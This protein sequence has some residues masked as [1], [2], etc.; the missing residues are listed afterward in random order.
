MIKMNMKNLAIAGLL[1]VLPTT[2]LAAQQ[3]ITLA[4]NVPSNKLYVDANGFTRDPSITVTRPAAWP[5][6]IGYWSATDYAW[7]SG[8]PGYVSYDAYATGNLGWAW[9]TIPGADWV[10]WDN[11]T[12]SPGMSYYMGADRKGP[13]HADYEVSFTMPAYFKNAKVD[14]KYSADDWM[15]AYMNNNLFVDQHT[16]TIG[17]YFDGVPSDACG[18][19]CVSTNT[20]AD[21]AMALRPGANKFKVRQWEPDGTGGVA[22]LVNITFDT[23]DIITSL[24]DLQNAIAALPVKSFK[25]AS[26]QKTLI[27]AITAEI[28][29][30][31]GGY[32]STALKKMNSDI[33]A[34]MN[35][36]ATIKKADANDMIITSAGQAATYPI[37]LKIVNLL[38]T[39]I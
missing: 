13:F 16:P 10:N 3:T 20:V 35:G 9:T 31:D 6:D 26:N 11:T 27:N 38:K 22:F 2:V 33:L 30:V 18:F 24:M 4:S 36:F 1:A 23:D 8:H 17:Q 28:K 37:A 29:T 14:I 5:S 32:N 7:P 12:S 25:V 19:S 15:N 21:A 39:R 34:M